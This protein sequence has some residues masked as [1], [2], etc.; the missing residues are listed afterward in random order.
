VQ[1]GPFKKIYFIGM[2]NEY[3]RTFTEVASLGLRLSTIWR[4]A[5]DASYDVIAKQS[6]PEQIILVRTLGGCGRLSFAN[7]KTVEAEADTAVIIRRR[8]ILRYR[9]TKPVW[10]FYWFEFVASNIK[11][12]PLCKLMHVAPLPREPQ[13]LLASFQ[14]LRRSEPTASRL[15]SAHVEYLLGQYLHSSQKQLTRRNQHQEVIEKVIDM[16]YADLTMSTSE[17]AAVACLSERRFRQVFAEITGKSPK[18][19]QEMVRLSMAGDLIRNSPLSI[20]QISDRAGY[21]SPFYFS[22]AFKKRFGKS[23]RHYRAG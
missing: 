10:N 21:L 19:F 5:A 12:L 8:D 20:A 3:A 17:M 23:P 6:P 14:L 13:L 15:A 7:G 16:M 22:R 4:V 18:E 2:D 1:V 9:C 11:D